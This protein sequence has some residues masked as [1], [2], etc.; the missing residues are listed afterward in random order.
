VPDRSTLRADCARCAALCCVAPTFSRS[1]EFAFD[2]PASVPCKHLAEDLGCSIHSGLR[3]HGFAGCATYDCFGAGQRVTGETFAG[4]TWRDDPGTADQVFAVFGVMRGLHEL[5]WH[6]LEARALVGPGPLHDELARAV[7]VTEELTCADAS[8]LEHLD[9][10]DHRGSAVP[11]LRRT[12]RLVREADGPGTDHDGED[13]VGADLR[14][15]DLRSA[16]LRSAVLVGADLRGLDLGR[17]DLTGADLRAADLRGT[18]LSSALFLTQPQLEAAR[19]D[20]HTR[21]PSALRRPLH[22]RGA[23]AR[24]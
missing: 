9:L 11:L 18:D 15:A 24:G 23:D 4:R 8:T 6:L 16:S 3:A 5:L 17:A 20:E 21:I 7:V 13:L 10:G 22:W 19:G 12:A 2:K 14:R 1:T